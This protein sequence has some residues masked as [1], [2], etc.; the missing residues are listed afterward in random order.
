MVMFS[1]IVDVLSPAYEARFAER[2]LWQQICLQAQSF[3]AA[4]MNFGRFWV[5]GQTY[6]RTETQNLRGSG[7]LTPTFHRDQGCPLHGKRSLCEDFLREF[8]QFSVQ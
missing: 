3:P 7:L 6:P 4:L 2:L 1:I 5:L 8:L